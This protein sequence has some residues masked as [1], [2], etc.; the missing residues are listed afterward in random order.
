MNVDAATEPR[1]T[2][3]RSGDR[4]FLVDLGSLEGAMGLRAQLEEHPPSGVSDVVAAARTVLVVARS[5]RFVRPLIEYVESLN[6]SGRSGRIGRTIRIPVSYEGEDLRETAARMGRSVESLIGWHSS[7]TWTAAFTGFA[8]GFV[9]LVGESGVRV[10]RRESPRTSVPAG[11]V[12][13][14]DNYSAVYPRS[15]PGGWQLI[16]RTDETL[17]DES[18]AD[19]ARIHPGDRV[20]FVPVRHPITGSVPRVEPVAPIERDRADVVIVQPGVGATI[21]DLGRPGHAVLGVGPAGAMDRSSFRQANR[22]VGNYAGQAAI[23][24]LGAGFS[25]RAETDQVVAVTG[26]AG[27]LAI[28]SATDRTARFGPRNPAVRT[29]F[30]LL[31]GEELT[32]AEADRGIWSYAAIRGG[33]D[34]PAVL[35]SRSRDTHSGI[36]PS[37]LAPGDGLVIRAADVSAVASN[38][39]GELRSTVQDTELR[40]TAPETELRSA[41]QETD[42]RV[43]PG[44]REDWFTT[45]AVDALF[46]E[47]WTVSNR[48]SRMASRLTGRPLER[49]VQD[50]LQSEGIVRGSIQVPPDGQPLIFGA[51][52][53]V[54]GGYPVIGVIVDADLDTAAQLGPGARVRFVRNARAET[55]DGQQERRADS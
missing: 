40:S 11:S 7:G 36:G 25:I 23:E 47:T 4:A 49:A 39:E 37:P 42:L 38:P 21:Q 35:E 6:A 29:P 1:R 48:F 8:P 2:V 14:A 32:I 26:A 33:I 52:H 13:L 28:R 54:T 17:W 34:A 30:V 5:P 20:R 55:D 46:S 27:R 12:G 50:E 43:I 16:G 44:P 19:P 10:P 9:Y 3:K 22:L 15:S 24:A 45:D 41:A 31:A 18:L 53:P 51:D